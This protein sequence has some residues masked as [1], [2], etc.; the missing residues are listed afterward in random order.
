MR[1]DELKALWA[2]GRIRRVEFYG[3]VMEWHTRWTDQSRT[4]YHLNCYRWSLLPRAHAW[5]AAR[6][7]ATDSAST[8]T[9]TELEKS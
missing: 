6:K 7:T 3:K 4:L 9:E 2:E 5:I 1:Q 8:V